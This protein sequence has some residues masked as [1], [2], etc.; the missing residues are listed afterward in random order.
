MIRVLLI[1]D[2]PLVIDSL[3]AGVD[4][5]R[6]GYSIV[7]EAY[8]GSEGL[9]RIEA[10]H[11]H[12]V[13]TDIRMPKLSGLEM[14]KQVQKK[15][16]IPEFILI[17]GYAEFAYA[18]KALKYGVAGY[19]LKP[20][21]EDEIEALLLKLK[22]TVELNTMETFEEGIEQILPM[23]SSEDERQIIKRFELAS[24]RQNMAEMQSAMEDLHH[25]L[26]VEKMT[27]GLLYRTHNIIMSYLFRIEPSYYDHYALGEKQL[28]AKYSSAEEMICYLKDQLGEQQRVRP[29]C[30]PKNIRNH[31]FRKLIDYVNYHYKTD[32]TLHV[33]AEEFMLNPSYISQMFR[34]EMK[35][36]YTNYITELRL[37]EACRLLKETTDS[38]SLI[39]E[40]VGFGDSFHFSRTFKK[41][42]GSAPAKYRNE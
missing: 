30:D 1:D 41:Y 42:I 33:L 23:M 10:L 4:W 28:F 17:S 2:E 29:A 15:E 5:E 31:T 12:V 18:Q 3:K 26:S 40:K 11:P 7:G 16:H 21:D 9:Q 22:K 32:L 37:G 27:S 24:A 34:K 39:S 14:I 36:T 13:F 38:V 20:F 8:D 35:M 19:C 6:C 25:R